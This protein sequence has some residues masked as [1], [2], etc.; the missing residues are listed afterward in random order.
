MSF[1]WRTTVLLTLTAFTASFSFTAEN[2]PQQN[3]Q[4]KAWLVLRSGLQDRKASNRTVAVQALSL[5]PGNRRA[6]SFAVSALQDKN[7]GVRTAAAVALG[8]QHALTAIPAL[9]NALEDPEIPVVLAAAHSLL[10]LKDPSAY[11]IFYAVLM[12]DKKSSVGLVQSQLNRLKD[13]KQLAQIGFEQGIGFVPFGG[14]GYEAYRTI[15]THDSSPVR[16][17]MARFLADDPDPISE[18]A[19]IQTALADKDEIVRLAALDA[20]NQRGDTHCIGRLVKNLSDDEKPAVRYRT[21]AV[22]LHLSAVT[23]KRRKH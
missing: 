2:Q 10:L 5:L 19:L 18:D 12:G 14:M 13:P 1:A 16:A 22:I 7:A 20:L 23:E 8:Q 3:P 11:Q 9:K 6:T 21:A 15:H 4:E 17:T